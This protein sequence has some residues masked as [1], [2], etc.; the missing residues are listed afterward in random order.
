MNTE[1]FNFNSEN[2]IKNSSNEKF[3]ID[4]ILNKIE[5]LDVNLSEEEVLNINKKIYLTYL[6]FLEK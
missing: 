3:S 4:I 2:Y 6:N 1:Y 5:K